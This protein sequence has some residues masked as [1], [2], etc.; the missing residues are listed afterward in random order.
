LPPREEPDFLAKL[1]EFA[2]LLGQV[3]AVCLFSSDS[4]CRRV[5]E[6]GFLAKFLEFI[7]LLGQ[8]LAV[9]LFFRNSFCRRV[10]E[11]DFLAKLLEFVELLG[12]VLAV[13]LF[14]SDSFCCRVEEPDFLTKLLEFVELFGQVLAV[15]LFSCNSFCRRVEKPGFVDFF[16][17][18]MEICRGKNTTL[19]LKQVTRLGI[20]LDL[21][22]LDCC[23][24]ICACDSFTSRIRNVNL[25][26]LE[27][28]IMTECSSH[29]NGVPVYRFQ[30]YV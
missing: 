19:P 27:A 2:E 4:F 30:K 17:V 25:A 8:V 20:E 23:A 3:L 11:P 10:E 9:R 5:E 26:R 12:Q 6:P 18:V 1:L 22:E 7:E 28:F 16:V 29:G 13:R 14:S 21:E 24:A 15:C